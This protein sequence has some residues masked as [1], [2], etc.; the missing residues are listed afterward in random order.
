MC[1]GYQNGSLFCFYFTVIIYI[2]LNKMP[3]KLNQ[4]QKSKT[5]GDFNHP[6]I[7]FIDWFI[8]Y[9]WETGTQLKLVQVIEL[10]NMYAT[11]IF[12]LFL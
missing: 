9:C 8:H 11:F 6:I 12:I 2:F 10:E 1:Q 3:K 4:L 7:W 5:I